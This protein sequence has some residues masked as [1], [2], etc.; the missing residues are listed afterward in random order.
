MKLR[1][2]MTPQKKLLLLLSA[3]L[4]GLSSFSPTRAE[5]PAS[6]WHG[7]FDS[8]WGEQKYQFDF[9]VTE[10]KLI[11][12]AAAEMGD[13]QR[14]VE[15]IDEK[16]ES[17]TLTFAERRKFQDNQM[18]IEYTGKVTDKG[19]AFTRRAGE[20]GRAEF[21]ASRVGP[22]PAPARPAHP[23]VHCPRARGRCPPRSESPAACG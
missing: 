5:S 18:R 17:N 9:K 19:L 21:V 1:A 4:A 13:Q 20:F 8:P 2:D 10:R 22:P 16:L 23:T 12:T 3:A 15:I 14:E 7:K 11:A 6:Q